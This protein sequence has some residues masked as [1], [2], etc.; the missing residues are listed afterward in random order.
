MSPSLLEKYNVPVNR[1]V[2]HQGEF[3]ITFPFGYH[4][5]YNLGFNCAESVNFALDSWIEIGKHAKACS[6]VSDSVTIDVSSLERPMET[7]A[8]DEE[9]K[10][11]TAPSSDTICPSKKTKRRKRINTD[12]AILPAPK[13]VSPTK[14][15]P[16]DNRSSLRSL[17]L[18]VSCALIVLQNRISKRR[19]TARVLTDDV[20]KSFQ[21]QVSAITALFK[22]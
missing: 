1:C 12:D 15:F 17:P 6:C 9:D 10:D 18:R 13:K 11:V 20:P 16:F 7:D 14:F 19:M 8:K 21:K 5:G 3:M 2:Q 4:A 22:A